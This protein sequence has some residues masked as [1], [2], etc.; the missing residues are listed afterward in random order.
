[1]VP[2]I[3]DLFHL[4]LS[5]PAYGQMLLLVTMLHEMELSDMSDKWTCA[6]N[7]DTYSSQRGYKLI[8]KTPKVSDT[9][10]LICRTKCQK[11]ETW[12]HLFLRCSFARKKIPSATRSRH[13]TTAATTAASLATGPGT[14]GSHDVVRPTSHRRRRRPCSW[15]MQASSHLQRHR[16]QRHSSTLMS[17]KHALS[18]ATAPTRT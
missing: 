2:M 3:E 5:A 16:S 4:L 7:T 17:L 10:A 11:E 8:H 12:N 13:E 9:F 1:M 15:H 18:S 6:N 14:V